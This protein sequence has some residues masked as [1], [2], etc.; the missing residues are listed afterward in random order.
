MYACSLFG[1]YIRP[2]IYR[3]YMYV[4]SCPAEL[5]ISSENQIVLSEMH[6]GAE[7]TEFWEGMGGR[8]RLAYDS[9]PIGRYSHLL[10][11]FAML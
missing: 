7:S 6:E 4:F 5:G 9:L 3:V 11:G 8:K 10:C 2:K 1:F